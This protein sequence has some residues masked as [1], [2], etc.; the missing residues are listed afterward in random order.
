MSFFDMDEAAREYVNRGGEKDRFLLEAME[1]WLHYRETG[2]HVTL[3]EISEWLN[4]IGTDHEIDPP[5]S[6]T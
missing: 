1:S 6:H 4:S 2:L 5:K 3:A